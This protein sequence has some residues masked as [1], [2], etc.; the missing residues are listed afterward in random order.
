MNGTVVTVPHP[1]ARIEGSHVRDMSMAGKDEVFWKRFSIAVHQ[2]EEKAQV[3]SRSLTDKAGST[4][5]LKPLTLKFVYKQRAG[6]S[7]KLTSPTA[8]H[9]YIGTGAKHARQSYVVGLLF[10]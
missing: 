9:G 6:C 3:I 5:S 4:A 8:I 2:D 7:M 10:Y 1:S